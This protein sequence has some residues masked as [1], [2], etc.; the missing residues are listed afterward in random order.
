MK[1]ILLIGA[2]FVAL[3]WIVSTNAEE[4]CP[5]PRILMP[6]CASNGRT[7][8]NMCEFECAAKKSNLKL[9]KRSSCESDVDETNAEEICPCP[10]NYSPVCA[11][12]GRTF[13]NMC[14]FECVAKK[15]NLKLLKRS[16]CEPKVYA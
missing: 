5:C 7:Y 8:N 15:S 9:V 6:V 4:I 3:V 12:N 16:A 13:N 11:S 10:R 14:E 2:L 1:T